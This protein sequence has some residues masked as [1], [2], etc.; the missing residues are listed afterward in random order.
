MGGLVGKRTV[1]GIARP[2]ERPGASVGRG[3]RAAKQ[4]VGDMVPGLRELPEQ[5]RAWERV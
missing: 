5:N 4:E 3:A 2:E 1:S